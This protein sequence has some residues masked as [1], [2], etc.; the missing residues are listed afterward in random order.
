[1]WS[2]LKHVPR[3]AGQALKWLG[4]DPVTKNVNV[5]GLV[6]R[7]APD[8]IFG[9]MAAVQTPG[10]WMDKAI[11]GGSSFAGGGLGGLVLSKAG[12]GHPGLSYGLDMAGSIGG[13]YAGMAVGDQLMRG[14]DKVTGGKGETPW[15]K[16]GAE[17]QEQMR[18]ELEQQILWQYGL[19]PGTREQYAR[20]AQDSFMIDNGLG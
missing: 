16:M 20:P 4:T 2:Q 18:N 9:T 8:A 12:M 3:F 11:A 1:M 10:D 17:Q 7:L 13:D 14:K 15:E 6:G 5:G 19:V